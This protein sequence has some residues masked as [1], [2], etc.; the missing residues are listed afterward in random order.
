[1]A[2]DNK[3]QLSNLFS[4]ITMALED[5]HLIA[6]RGMSRHLTIYHYARIATHILYGVIDLLVLATKA[7]KQTKIRQ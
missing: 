6:S 2:S 3:R 7:A 1:M 5:M 4:Q